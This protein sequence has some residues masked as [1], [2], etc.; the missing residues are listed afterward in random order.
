MRRDCA[1]NYQNFPVFEHRSRYEEAAKRHDELNNYQT[2]PTF[3]DAPKIDAAKRDANPPI[4]PRASQ[5]ARAQSGPANV[6]PP[7]LE[8]V[9]KGREKV[10]SSTGQAAL[11]YKRIVD[12]RT[13]D[14]IAPSNLKLKSEGPVTFN[15]AERTFRQEYGLTT[16]E[17]RVNDV[18][19]RL[20]PGS[21]RDNA[22]LLIEKNGDLRLESTPSGLKPE[23]R[24]KQIEPRQGFARA[25]NSIPGPL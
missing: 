11:P 22:R 3:A 4:L 2:I 17:F 10:H 20:R 9:L 19:E 24:A 15:K 16:S 6:L 14:V 12:G 8:E 13:V 1:N 5:A 7:R 25:A 21:D 23:A 18:L